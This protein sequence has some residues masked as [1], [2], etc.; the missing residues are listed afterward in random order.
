MADHPPCGIYR[1]TQALEGIPAGR[2]V[3]FHNHGDPGP[4]IY[5]PERWSNN[6]A[7][8]QARGATVPSPAWSATLAPIAAEGLYRVSEEFFCCDKRCRKYE[9]GLLVQLGYDGEAHPLL[10]VPEWTDAG[11]SFPLE[12][13]KFEGVNL[14]RLEPLKVSQAAPAPGAP[15]SPML[16]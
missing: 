7:Q 6:R 14:S 15:R 4:G 11:M 1:T 9:V 10:F 3:Y 8:W 12:G 16:H 2:L 5:L 13:L